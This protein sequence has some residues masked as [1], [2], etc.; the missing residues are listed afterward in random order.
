[1]MADPDD[2]VEALPYYVPNPIWLPREQR[3]G[4]YVKFTRDARLTLGLDDLLDDAR[5]IRTQSGHPVLVLI[6]ERL[7][8][9][10]PARDV[11][12]VYNWTLSITPESTA[13]FLDATERLARFGPVCCS[14]ETFD[15]YLL[16]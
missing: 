1:V 4:S 16:K 11:H 7:E 15:V 3:L 13:R 14:P 6:R 8:R 2:L 5:R 9:D 12:E 10:G